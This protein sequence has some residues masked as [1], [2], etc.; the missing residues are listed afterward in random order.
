[1]STNSKKTSI[2]D[3]VLG[4]FDRRGFLGGTESKQEEEEGEERV[5]LVDDDGDE[6]QKIEDRRSMNNSES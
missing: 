1:M 4:F 3:S 2:V 5:N 6:E